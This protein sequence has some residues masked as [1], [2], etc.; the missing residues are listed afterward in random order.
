MTTTDGL[1]V[2]TPADWV[3]GPR[4]G[5]WTYD[6]YAAKSTVNRKAM[7]RPIGRAIA[8]LLTVL[9]YSLDRKIFTLRLGSFPLLRE[10]RLYRVAIWC[11]NLRI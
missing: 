3:P 8:F 6:D 9:N 5:S 2:V 10:I 1:S 4:Q 7:A 11:C